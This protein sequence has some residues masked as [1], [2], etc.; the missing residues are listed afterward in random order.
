[1]QQQQQ[2][3]EAHRWSLEWE[4]RRFTVCRSPSSSLHTPALLGKTEYSLLR[5]RGTSTTG[6]TTGDS[7]PSS[8]RRHKPAP[9][10]SSW[11]RSHSDVLYLDRE[12]HSK[13]SNTRQVKHHCWQFISVGFVPNAAAQI[14]YESHTKMKWAQSSGSREQLKPT[15]TEEISLFFE[16]DPCTGLPVSSLQTTAPCGFVHAMLPTKLRLPCPLHLQGSWL[17]S[18]DR[19]DVQSLVENDWNIELLAQ[20]PRLCVVLLQWI[21]QLLGSSSLSSSSSSSSSSSARAESLPQLS[22]AYQILPPLEVSQGQTPSAIQLSARVLD[23]SICMREVQQAALL[24]D[25]VPAQRGESLTAS[26]CSLSTMRGELSFLP[27]PRVIWLPAPFLQH[28]PAGFLSEWWGG[29]V[30]FASVAAGD[31]AFHP[32]WRAVVPRPT[33]DGL[34]RSGRGFAR[35]L[36]AFCVPVQ[37]RV[38]C[39]SGGSSGSGSGLPLSSVDRKVFLGVRVLAALGG[40]LSLS[41]PLKYVTQGASSGDSGDSNAGKRNTGKPSSG[42]LSKAEK[43]HGDDNVN[44]GLFG[45]WLPGIASWPV[46]LV[47]HTGHSTLPAGHTVTLDDMIFLHADFNAPTLPSEIYDLLRPAAV[48][49][50]IVGDKR[51]SENINTRDHNHRHTK[52][53]HNRWKPSKQEALPQL[54]LHFL[55]DHDVDKVLSGSTTDAKSLQTLLASGLDR[56]TVDRANQCL[57]HIREAV[58][59]Q[60]VVGV[61]AACRALLAHWAREHQGYILTAQ[62]G[63]VLALFDWAF[64]HKRCAAM[65]HFLVSTQD[66]NKRGNWDCSELVSNLKLVPASEAYIDTN[67]TAATLSAGTQSSSLP[68]SSETN[69][70]LPYLSHLYLSCRDKSTA[71]SAI[72]DRHIKKC[73]DFFTK[74]GAQQG[75]S[76]IA[77]KRKISNSETSSYLEGGVL[78]KLRSSNTSVDLHLPFSLGVITRK[79]VEV[80]DVDLV[81]EVSLVH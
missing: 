7:G 81:E 12:A 43:P 18:V 40:C 30:P 13:A 80:L 55:L 78:P 41:P 32:L 45:D 73:Q 50:K 25:I 48:S 19:Q 33:E 53:K 28:L 54:P 44:C 36:T 22:L 58:A 17:L 1:V 64:E 15:Q 71:A 37:V 31:T 20:F 11:I 67:I 72:T 34:R 74:C 4:G 52:N 38:G 51:G 57:D 65:S 77:F 10:P 2:S 35:A 79:R 6:T 27:A 56:A 47:D 66:S 75:I 46:F 3:G 21:A 59:P 61:D 24:E 49:V 16:V 9:S 76:L 60:R 8:S 5:L 26:S 63:H 39:G 23:Q 14:S 62:L 70:D 29:L 69:S 68:S 42:V